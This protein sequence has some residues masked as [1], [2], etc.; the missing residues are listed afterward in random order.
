MLIPLSGAP[1]LG[2]VALFGAGVPPVVAAGAPLADPAGAVVPGVAGPCGVVG[3]EP[4]VE[5][6][7]PP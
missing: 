7:L 4:V 3:V 2:V 5:V 1:L 6:E